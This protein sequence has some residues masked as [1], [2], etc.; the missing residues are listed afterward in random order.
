MSRPFVTKSIE[1]QTLTWIRDS[2]NLFDYDDPYLVKQTFQ[3]PV[4]SKVLRLADLCIVREDCTCNFEDAGDVGI[5]SLGDRG[6]EAAFISLER[7]G[8]VW[9]VVR[10]MSRCT[11]EE[12]DV[13]R[14]GRAELEVKQ[15][16]IFGY[17]EPRVTPGQ[18]STYTFTFEP[19]GKQAC[20]ICL[21]D[22]HTKKDPLIS[23][24]QCSGS[25]QYIH[26][27]CLR[28]WLKTKLE[29]TANGKST[30]YTSDTPTCELCKSPFPLLI[31]MDGTNISLMT[32]LQPNK[33]F[34][35]LQV[36]NTEPIEPEV[37]IYVIGI[38]DGETAVIVRPT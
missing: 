28:E 20:R 16:C 4:T 14:V 25:V 21:S 22:T 24:C 11:V 27:N 23:P 15:I 8:G 2:N 30:I 13:F 17:D 37:N 5:V 36:T 3:L 31:C 35:V 26:V 38:R 6:K 1:L 32:I 18:T 9:E 29:T 19:G 12:G 10:T 33:P 34:I 7:D